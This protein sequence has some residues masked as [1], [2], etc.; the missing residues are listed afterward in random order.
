M[1]GQ[2][3]QLYGGACEA[4]VALDVMGMLDGQCLLTSVVSWL[5]WGSFRW[6]L[7]VEGPSRGGGPGDWTWSS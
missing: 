1:T 3:L 4:L 7:R 2:C 5:G 6:S